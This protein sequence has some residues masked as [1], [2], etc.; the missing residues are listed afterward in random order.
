V[1]V[2]VNDGGIS[3][4]ID[5]RDLGKVD[6]T[7]LERRFAVTGYDNETGEVIVKV[8]NSDAAP[9]STRI[10]LDGAKGI[11]KTGKAI[12]LSSASLKDDNSFEE[13]EKVSPVTRDVKGLSDDFTYTF[14]PYS[15]T[16]LRFKVSL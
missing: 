16:I 5:G 13:P 6:Y 9:M 14:D 4:A 1:N 2:S 3:C 12:V 7:P 8:V 15:L 10:R 11:S